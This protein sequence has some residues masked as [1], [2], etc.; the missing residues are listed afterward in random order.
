MY[1]FF[2]LAYVVMKPKQQYIVYVLIPLPSLCGHE[3]ETKI[4]YPCNDSFT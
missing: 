2:Y 1:W 4:Y 3:A